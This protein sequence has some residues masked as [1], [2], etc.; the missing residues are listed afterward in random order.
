MLAST[1]CEAL[2][3]RRCLELRYD[4]FTRIVEV[5]AVGSTKDGTLILR[6]WQVHGGSSSG[7]MA[8]WKMMR[9]DDVR[10][11]HITEFPSGAPR[12]GYRRGDPAMSD[13]ICQL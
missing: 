1:A 4:G 5:H 2:A 8:G 9:L 7:E 11:G 6:V 3:K 13:I 12:D 10:S